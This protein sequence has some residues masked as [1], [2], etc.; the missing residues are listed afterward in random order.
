M[1]M[2]NKILGLLLLSVF[3]I[4]CGSDDDDKDLT[5]K[6]ESDIIYSFKQPL[7][8]FAKDE[9]GHLSTITLDQVLP[10]EN[11]GFLSGIFQGNKSLL[12]VSDF[13]QTNPTLELDNFVITVGQRSF[14]LGTCKVGGMQSEGNFAP[15]REYSGNNETAIAKAIYDAV[16][17]KEKK[18]DIK[19]SY[20][21]N[22]DFKDLELKVNFGA[23]YTHLVLAN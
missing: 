15:G 3:F 10:S 14:N 16:T 22:E 19:V 21:P 9:V 23:L 20:V 2:M 5:K 6:V 8:G 17:S 1:K 13:T 11:K 4:S 12:I 18:V 7:R